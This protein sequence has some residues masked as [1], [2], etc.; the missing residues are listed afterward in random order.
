MRRPSTAAL[1]DIW[2]WKRNGHRAA[3]PAP[4]RP[5]ATVR[6]PVRCDALRLTMIGHASLLIQVDGCNI[7]L[8]PVWSDRASPVGFAGPRRHTPPGI[9]FDDLPPIDLV[10][11]THNHY[12]HMDL[13]TLRRLWARDQPR[14]I[15]PLGN[16]AILP[17]PSQT[18]DWGDALTIT[19]TITLAFTPANH[20]SSRRMSDRR[21]ALWCGYVL[22]SNAGLL[23][24]AGD[25]G[26]GGGA[27][28]RFIRDEFG[29]P[30]V[31]ILPIGA[32]EPRWF[33]ASQHMNPDEAVQ[34][35]LLLGA[36][37]ALGVHW[38]CFQL[39]DEAREAPLEALIAARVAQR[40]MPSRFIAM[41][42]GQVWPSDF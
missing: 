8:D 17:V 41:H 25:S 34:A 35:F 42:A 38:G 13:P 40:I 30:D 9:A 2:R 20:W 3:W 22:R 11:L 14:I 36:R 6:P 33:M 21:R 32:Y 24:C 1:R 19:D 10:L 29:R 12:D 16:D 26:F 5:G 28:F 31:A 27:L 23:Y 4:P 7:L 37:Q 18:G 15:A 39:T